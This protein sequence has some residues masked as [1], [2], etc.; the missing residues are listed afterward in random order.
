MTLDKDFEDFVFLLNKYDVNYMIIGGYALAFHGRPR[1]TGDLDIWIDVSEENARKMFN[2]INE[3]GLAS[4]GL[5]I[6]DFLEKGIITQIGY[7]PLRIDILNE[8][9][10]V[11]FNEA[12]QNKLIIDIDGLP[13]S[14]ISLDDLIKNKQVSGRQRDL[15]DVSE[16]NKL[17]KNK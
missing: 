1:H 9:D 17:K 10:G 16:L 5:K 8:I 13:I 15:S 4:L 14:Y 6:E 2:V 11:Q 3:F 7:P 12:Y